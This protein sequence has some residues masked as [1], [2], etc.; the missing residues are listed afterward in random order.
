MKPLIGITCDHNSRTLSDGTVEYAQYLLPHHYTVA[1]E[2]A[3]GVPI[4]L[5]YRSGPESIAR[6]VQ[7]CDGFVL[8]GG[9]DYDP[10]VWGESRHP[11]AIGVDPLRETFDRALIAAIEKKNAPV[12]GICGGCQL[13][14]IH[15]GGTLHQFIPDL[16]LSPTIDH[17]R[18]TI[19]EWAKRHDVNIRPD[20]QLARVMGSDRAISN[21][22]H[23]QA[24]HVV[25]KQL[26]VTAH[27]PDGVV[28]AIEDPARKFYIG[29]QWHPERQHDEPDQLRL[30]EALVAACGE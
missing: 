7:L 29:V 20:S 5:P 28:E 17:R 16:G 9:N 8:S 6:Y 10:T 3:G 24:V 30:F 18:H 22:S 1:V 11:K 26:V 13:M 15:R 23:K 4:V 2:K 25:G 14:N 12:L 19:E 21:T 27:A